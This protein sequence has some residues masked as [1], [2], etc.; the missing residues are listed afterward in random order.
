MMP[1][2]LP[3][4]PVKPETIP[5]GNVSG[6]GKQDLDIVRLKHTIRVWVHVRDKRVVGPVAAFEEEGHTGNESKHGARVL[7]VGETDGNEKRAG[8]DRVNVDERLLAPH[9][10]AAVKEV[11]ENSTSGP[12]RDVEQTKHGSPSSGPSLSKRGEVLQVVGTEN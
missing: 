9:A 6:G 7:G 2:K 8:D 4:A 5:I 12:E 10:R 3:M 11:G 1:P